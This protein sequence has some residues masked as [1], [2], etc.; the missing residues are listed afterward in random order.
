MKF[1]FPDSQDLVDPSFDFETETRSPTR[2]RQRDD[3]YAHEVFSKPPYDGML[4]SKAIVDGTGNGSGRYTLGQRHRFYRSG[5]RE[6]LRLGE[7]PLETMGDC[8]AFTYV[9][10]PEPPVTVDEVIGFYAECGFDYGLS[11]DHMI[12][13]YDSTLD[14]ASPKSEAVPED[15]KRRQQITFDYANKFYKSHKSG[16]HSFTPVGVAQGW[17]PKSYAAAVQKLQNIG[18]TRVALGGMV[19][20][21]TEEVMDCLEAIRG[22]RRQST[23][24]HLLGLSRCEHVAEFERYGVTSFDSTSPLRQAFKDDRDNYY[25]PTRTYPAIRVPQVEGNPSLKKMIIAGKVKQ[26]EAIRLER[27][28]MEALQHFDRRRG[29]R[30]SV[31][32]LLKEYQDLYEGSRDY[33]EAYREILTDKPWQDCPCDVCRRLGIHVVLFRGA[34]RNRRRGFHNVFVTY[35]KLCRRRGRSGATK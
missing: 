21:K 34:E 22:V 27:A 15:W 30:D 23:Q 20:L 35:K 9:N 14:S 7:R 6:F 19:P 2:I 29:S 33:T 24:L 26:E 17:S 28:C 31:V 1:F 10:E 11:V 4:V 8:G 16:K 13:A 5:V 18:Y 25:A 32:K 3:Q 12:L